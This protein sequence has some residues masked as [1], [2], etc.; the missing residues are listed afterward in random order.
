MSGRE[1]DKHRGRIQAQ[2]GGFESSE[3]WSQNSPLSVSDGLH[4]LWSLIRKIPKPEFLKR[5][6]EFEK[7]E[8]FIQLAGDKGGVDARVSK[9]FKAKGTKDIRVDIEVIKGTAFVKDSK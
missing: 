7:A 6:S 8:N 5:K 4:L 1:E 2:G 3:S 9:T